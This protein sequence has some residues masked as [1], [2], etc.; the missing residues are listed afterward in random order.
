MLFDFDRLAE[1]SAHKNACVQIACE[2]KIERF[3]NR[4]L[5]PKLKRVRVQICAT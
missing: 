3:D 4:R 5:K 1:L 2:K